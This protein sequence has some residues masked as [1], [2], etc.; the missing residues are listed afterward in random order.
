MSPPFSMEIETESRELANAGER[1]SAEMSREVARFARRAQRALGLRGEIGILLTSSAAVRRLN[2]Q[3]RK[4]DKTTDVLS[5]PA[6]NGEMAGDIA[7]ALPVAAAQ[8]R[9][10]GHALR[11]EVKL[12]VLHGLLHLA[13][14]DHE[15]DG[16]R[17]AR[18]EEKLR[19]MLALP[20][21]L[22]LRKHARRSNASNSA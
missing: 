19:R 12:L 9:R 5:F 17:M 22:I 20:G 13:G 3:F 11:D 15:Q 7:I 4:K 14:Y 16:G 2:R 8:A 21:G 18:K 1:A 10:F 6:A